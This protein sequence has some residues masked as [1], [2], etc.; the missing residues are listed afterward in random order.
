MSATKLHEGVSNLCIQLL[1][2]NT[3]SFFPYMGVLQSMYV[4]FID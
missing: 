4:N 2:N 3:S 1:S